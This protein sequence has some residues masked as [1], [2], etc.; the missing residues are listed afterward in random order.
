LFDAAFVDATCRA[1]REHVQP[2]ALGRKRP[3]GKERAM[4]IEQAKRARWFSLAK[5][6]E[7]GI[8]QVEFAFRGPAAGRRDVFLRLGKIFAVRRKVSFPCRFVSA[9]VCAR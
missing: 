7:G 4:A 2:L 5:L 8:D 1:Q 6:R 9:C 3:R